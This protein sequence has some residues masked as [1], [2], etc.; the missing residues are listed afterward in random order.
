MSKTN[1]TSIPGPQATP[2]YRSPSRLPADARSQ[3]TGALAG[4]LSD[5]LDLH[6]QIKVAHWNV[7][8]PHFAAFHPLFEGFATQ[9]AGFNDE[10]AE[11]AVTLGARVGGTVRDVVLTSRL[12]ALPPEAVR[13]LELAGLLA[14]RFEQY[15]DGV[16]AARTVAERAGDQDT[17]DLLTGV[18]EAFEKNG[19]FLRASLER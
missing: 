19:W 8:G 14:E 5:G 10:V 11:R 4:V 7:K 1:L 9:L 17:Q 18:V 13:D 12:A 15:L 6:S 16:R 3:I 2:T